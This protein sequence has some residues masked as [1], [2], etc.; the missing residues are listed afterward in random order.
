[1]R[2]GILTYHCVPNFGAQLQTLS[3][4]GFL[5]KHG[6]EPIVLNWYPTDLETMYMKRVPA[7]QIDCHREFT[8]KVLPITDVCRTETE[9]LLQIERYKLEGLIVG[10]DA[11]FKYIPQTCRRYFSRKRMWYRHRKVL[12]VEE[13]EGNPFFGGFIPKMKR[14]IPVVAF[15]VSSQNCPYMEMKEKERLLMETCMRNYSNIS[16]RDEW[17]QQMV[18]YVIQQQHVNITPDP[19]FSFNT[20]V[21]IEVPTKEDII[22]K[23]GLT[24]DYVLISFRTNYINSKYVKKLEEE[25]YHQGLQAVAF[26]MP[27]GLKDFGIQTRIELPLNPID[28]Y[29][30][31]K[32]SSGYIGERMHP[33]VVAIHNSV[34][35]YVFDEYGTFHK[36]LL[37]RIKDFSK[38]SSKTYLILHEA[39]LEECYHSYFS[40]LGLE[41][42]AK[43][44]EKVLCFDKNKCIGFSTHCKQKYEEA[45][46]EAV[47][48]I[49]KK[50]SH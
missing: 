42:V 3:T 29:A 44:V 38:M 32:Y 50:S 4:V 43:V 20:N 39:K 33:I 14:K 45:M 24:S 22:K 13:I 37:G 48:Y 40:G 36:D 12:S 2:I 46:L 30:L 10:S 49:Q 34:P 9:L 27:E 8:K 15:S 25:L 1:M 7:L 21:G 18:K 41:P 19:V 35:F 16:V 6:F 26:P 17:T 28:W 5:R 31:I 47:S 11:L 23:Y